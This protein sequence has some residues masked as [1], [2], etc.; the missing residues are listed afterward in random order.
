MTRS[1]I[2]MIWYCSDK[3]KAES[4]KQNAVGRRMKGSRVEGIKG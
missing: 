2:G 4:R 1:F 3:K